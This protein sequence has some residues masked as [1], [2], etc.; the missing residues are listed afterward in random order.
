MVPNFFKD[1]FLCFINVKV[2]MKLT[3]KNSIESLNIV[4]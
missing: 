4:Q 2:K 3:W 1:H